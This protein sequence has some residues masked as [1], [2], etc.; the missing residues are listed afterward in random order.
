MIKGIGT[1]S[2]K[3]MKTDISIPNPIF[4]AATKLAQKLDMTLSEF[5]T[6]ALA[7]Y[8]ATYESD[9][10]TAQL[11]EV[12]EE[13]ESALEPELVALQVVSIGSESW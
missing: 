13:E 3:L 12:Y 6:A 5:Y 2:E 9:D 7:A 1:R 8:V 11:Y 4:E 10:I